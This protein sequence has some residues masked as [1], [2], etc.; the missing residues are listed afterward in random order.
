M[1]SHTSGWV[2]SCEGLDLHG[3]LGTFLCLLGPGHGRMARLGM[4]GRH[5]DLRKGTALT[6]VVRPLGVYV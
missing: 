6:A 5:I 1:N 4:Q 2:G 3:L